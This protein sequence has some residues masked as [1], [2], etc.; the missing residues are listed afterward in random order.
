[1]RVIACDTV[2]S[3][4]LNSLTSVRAV[5][6]NYEARHCAVYSVYSWVVSLIHLEIIPRESTGLSG[7]G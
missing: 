5:A 7:S 2:L 6:S 3:E 4:P 1:M